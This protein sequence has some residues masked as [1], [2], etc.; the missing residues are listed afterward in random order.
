MPSCWSQSPPL[1]IALPQA[2]AMLHSACRACRQGGFQCRS[3]SKRKCALGTGFH[4]H[5]WKG[6]PSP[7]RAQVAWHLP[8]VCT[9]LEESQ[10]PAWS[11]AAAC[12]RGSAPGPFGPACHRL[13]RGVP[14]QVTRAGP[15]SSSED[16]SVRQPSPPT[17]P[18]QRE[19]P[20]MHAA[21]TLSPESGPEVTLGRDCSGCRAPWVAAAR[22]K[23]QVR[24]GPCA[25]PGPRGGTTGARSRAV[26]CI[27]ELAF[28]YVFHGNSYRSSYVLWPLMTLPGLESSL[29]VSCFVPGPTQ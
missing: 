19:G 8:V 1:P 15:S 10:S 29:K 16:T 26:V 18:G 9:F 22:C 20:N 21:S 11:S 2:P 5:P 6:V 28:S 3:E 14:G 17:A 7:A 24:P 27:S 23:L 4:P 25:H 13:R 12:G